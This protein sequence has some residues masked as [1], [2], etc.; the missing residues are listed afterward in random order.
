MKEMRL[1]VVVLA[2]LGASA[3]WAA[4]SER[5]H[6]HRAKVTPVQKVI[7]LMNGM[8]AKGK[9]EKHAEQVQYAAYKQFCDDT[10]A[11]KT[12][13]IAEADEL[14]MKLKADIEKFTADVAQLTA[15][16]ADHEE[17]IAVWTG[18]MKAATLVRQIE[19]KDYDTTHTD[20]SESI[21][22]LKRAIEVLKA[23]DHDRSQAAASASFQQLRVLKDRTGFPLEARRTIQAFLEEG[24]PDE[25]LAVSAPEAE[26]YEFQ[27]SG[28]IE[29]LEKLLD[30]F[31]AERT[32]LEKE[33]LSSKQAYEMLMAD[34][35]NGI[36]AASADKDAKTETKA[37]KLEAKATAEGNL[38]DTTV[39]RDADQKYLDDLTA[40]CGQKASDFEARQQLRAEELLAVEKAI[41]IISSGA[42]AGNAETYMPTMLQFKQETVRQSLSQL[43]VT[44]QKSGTLRNR[45]TVYLQRRAKEIQSRLLDA[46]AARL[47]D[48]GENSFDPFVKVR[49]MIKDLIVKLMEEANDEAAHKGWCDTELATNEK[50]R[51]QKTEGVQML[52]ADIDELTASIAKLTEELAELSQAV[53]DLDKAMAD[54]TKLRGEEKE[55]NEETVK[56]AQEAQTA[57]AQAMTV[58]K[59]FY[60]TAA[61]A[62]AFVQEAKK[63]QRRQEPPAIFDSP[64]KGMGGEGG[65]VIGM[66]EVIQSDFA[67]LEAETGAA[68]ENAQKEYDAFMTDSKVDKE[69]KDTDIKHK[70]AKKQDEE[71]ALTIAK[72]D[73][74]ATQKELDAALMYFDKLKPTCVDADVSYEDRVARRKEEI[75]SLQEAL[76]ILQG[77]EIV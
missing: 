10:S 59:E 45:A 38:E 22:A 60:G 34:L 42:V 68:E 55:K 61:D 39:A 49:K 18:D 58:L 23:Q 17:D 1:P 46:L 40:T 33:E 37:K 27:S 62:T 16:I 52:N 24:Q 56:D 44:E 26:G 9:E 30:K 41:E 8:L 73:L 20:Y 19:K 65:G 74:E 69:S 11:E 31:I 13:A 75:E 15:D 5:N 21:D 48:T 77:K 66:L 43:R 32:T 72:Q 54:A 36:S 50:T 76:K 12:R 63:G 25:G 67:R 70:T 7:E 35:E 47:A 51:T 53:A 64:Y 14:M 3:V 57:V 71:G 6:A 4:E 29:M 28:I 2:L